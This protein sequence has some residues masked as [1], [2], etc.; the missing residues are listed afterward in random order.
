MIHYNQGCISLTC[1]AKNKKEL[2]PWKMSRGEWIGEWHTQMSKHVETSAPIRDSNQF[3]W[4][5]TRTYNL[6]I[7]I[8]S[9]CHSLGRV[10]P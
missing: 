2:R 4:T 1:Q 9:V 8:V 5:E 7:W 10:V 6:F 3:I